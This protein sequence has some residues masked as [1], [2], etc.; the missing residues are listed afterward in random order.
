MKK[1]LAALFAVLACCSAVCRAD[2]PSSAPVSSHTQAAMDLLRVTNVESM[3]DQQTQ[4]MMGAMVQQ[5]PQLAPFSDVIL[6][7]A[8]TYISWK[9]L[10]PQ[11]VSLYEANFTEAELRELLKFYQSP[12]GQKS[13]SK[14]PELTRSAMQVGM[15]AAQAHAPELIQM[16]N[17]RKAALD[18]AANN[19][20]AA[21][22]SSA[23]A[24]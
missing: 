20:A 15:A 17:E 5:N 4:A 1:R 16:I 8:G 23:P 19:A 11:F 3:I 13:L 24:N 6:K 21:A 18:K 22:G 9:Q 2:A 7:W 14:V 10:G 12:V